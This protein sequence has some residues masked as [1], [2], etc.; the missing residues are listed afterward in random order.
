MF[1]IENISDGLSRKNMNS[2]R[3]LK[4]QDSRE[5]RHWNTECLYSLT[6]LRL[7]LLANDDG[8]CFFYSQRSLP[9][10]NICNCAV[11]EQ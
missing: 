6:A 1:D 11:L 8:Y 10:F 4:I 7:F 5:K 2:I 3:G 9:F